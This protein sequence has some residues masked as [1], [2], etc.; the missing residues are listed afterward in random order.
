MVRDA[1]LPLP[2][3]RSVPVKKKMQYPSNKNNKCL[4]TSLVSGAEEREKKKNTWCLLFMDA[5]SS[6]GNLHPILLS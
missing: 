2:S 6:R 5:S 4:F 3:C 1:S